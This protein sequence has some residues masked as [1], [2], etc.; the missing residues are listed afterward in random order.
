MKFTMTSDDGSKNVQLRSMTSEMSSLSRSDG[1]ALLNQGDTSVLVAVY[2]PAEVKVM[3]ELIDRATVEVVYKPKVGIPGCAEKLQERLVR[4]S[5]EAVMLST[6]HPRTSINIVVQEMQNSG[7]LTSCC[8]NAACLALLDAGVPMKSTVAA[9]Q[10]TIDESDNI[11]VDPTP[12]EERDAT[13]TLIFA[14]ESVD[15]NVVLAKG[16]GEFSNE[17]YHRCL[18]ACQTA[19]TDVFAMYRTALERKLSKV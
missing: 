15:K 5:C 2:G 10:C 3:K 12:K 14:F 6:L 11:V 7:S 16:S 13:A 18:V 1:S 9:V 17:Q 4:N 8:I 19:A